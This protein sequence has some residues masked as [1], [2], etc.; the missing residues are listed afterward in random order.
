MPLRIV[1]INKISDR[2]GNTHSLLVGVQICTVTTEIS[3]AA[4]EEDGKN[5]PPDPVISL[6]GVYPK[7]LSSYHKGISSVMVIVAL[8]LTARIHNNLDVS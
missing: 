7:D 3:V 8:F 1:V 2:K 6:L 5:L 4:P